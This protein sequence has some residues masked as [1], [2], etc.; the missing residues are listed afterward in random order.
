[1]KISTPGLPCCVLRRPGTEGFLGLETIH[2]LIEPENAPALEEELLD[3]GFLLLPLD[4]GGI[5]SR[6][7]GRAPDGSGWICVEVRTELRYG[8]P[9]PFLRAP[10][11]VAKMIRTRRCG[12]MVSV[13]T[14]DA[15]FVDLLLHA[16]LD[17]GRISPS[18]GDHLQALMQA[19]RDRP[20]LAGRAAE[21]VQLNLAPAITWD[22]LV[23]DVTEG[24][25]DALLRRR[26]SL[27]FR[28]ARSAPR[29]TLVRIGT[30]W[31]RRARGYLGFPGTAR[32]PG[33][34]VALLAGDGGGKS[35]VAREL[36][37]QMPLPSRAIY[38]GYPR[39]LPRPVPVLRG[40][41]RMTSFW[42]RAVT[43]RWLKSRGKVVIADRYVYDGWIADGR[44]DPGRRSWRRRI[45]EW[46]FP[47]PDLVIILDAPGKLL[48]QRSK[49]L[50]PIL[51]E[52]KRAAYLA[53]GKRIPGSVVLDATRPQHEVLDAA[54]GHVWS[55]CRRNTARH[56]WSA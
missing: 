26:R 13:L 44:S 31:S 33:L 35:A 2:L 51:L 7:V 19:L 54:M 43:V 20:C 10:E 30:A 46:P 22:E 49:E 29:D 8:R 28:M 11:S 48:H 50:S 14:P 5:R 25:W 23:R 24:N 1:M 18:V 34:V 15:D 32:G 47:A 3:K 45:L 21:R 56:R 16:L 55:A 27:A 53:L 4:L 12:S 39:D 41:H 17:R 40:L 52:E 42:A 6:L 9:T 38:G 37:R 36:T